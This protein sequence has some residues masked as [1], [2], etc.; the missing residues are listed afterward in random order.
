MW[1]FIRPRLHGPCP[2]IAR[3]A[4]A[5]RRSPM[6][7]IASPPRQTSNWAKV[8]A[9]YLLADALADRRLS[10][11]PRSM[12]FEIKYE[13]VGLR[14]CRTKRF[15]VQPIRSPNFAG[16]YEFSTSL[17]LDG[18]HVTDDTGTG[19][20]HTALLATAGTISTSGWRPTVAMLREH[21][22]STRVSP[23][24]SMPTVAFS[25]TDAPG[26]VGQ[27]RVIDRQGRQGRCQRGG[28][29][30]ARSRPARSSRA[31][32]SSISTPTPGGR[33]NR[34][35]SATRRNGSSRWIR[36]LGSTMLL[37]SPLWGRVGMGVLSV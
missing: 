10:R 29:Q 32:G 16:S 28:H 21:A 15:E 25:P 9:T 19:F 4:F 20:V 33:K 6:A 13:S 17:F 5:S 14:S 23:T 31:G 1:L 30:G 34:L 26:F 3:L 36:G 27:A 18:D 7:F 11:L 37:P 22:G 12:T 2:P 24:R 35:S 8:G